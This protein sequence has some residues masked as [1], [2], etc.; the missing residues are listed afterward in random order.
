M[1][2]HIALSWGFAYYYHV[3]TY[4][5]TNRADTELI[6]GRRKSCLELELQVGTTR[7]DA[8]GPM[9]IDVSVFYGMV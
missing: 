3:S 4:D 5:T 1:C 2:Y 7:D 8:P 9:N 6:R